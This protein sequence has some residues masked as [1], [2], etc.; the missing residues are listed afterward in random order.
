M[1]RPKRRGR[2]KRTAQGALG[3]I[4]AST[5]GR[6]GRAR[7]L[8]S[9]IASTRTAL[10]RL[11]AGRES[12]PHGSVRRRSGTTRPQAWSPGGGE[13]GSS[14][15]AAPRRS[16][17]GA[18]AGGEVLRATR[19]D[20]LA[21]RR[22][23]ARRPLRGHQPRAVEPSETNQEVRRQVHE[24]C[25]G[26][27]ISRRA[28]RWRRP[29]RLKPRRDE[30]SSRRKRRPAPT[31]SR[32]RG[33]TSQRPVARTPPRAC[34]SRARAAATRARTSAGSPSSR[35]A[36]NRAPRWRERRR[37]RGTRSATRSSS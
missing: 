32:A 1:A 15:P 29:P 28:A 3:V 14:A 5:R 34:A 17:E 25:L 4:R 6:Q 22:S 7:R 18:A 26:R 35:S 9:E 8:R 36:A 2:R 30:R 27:R 12:V 19:Q 13:N 16:P 21:R 23:Q 37:P 24:T 33:S 11:I 20:V 10:G 31:R